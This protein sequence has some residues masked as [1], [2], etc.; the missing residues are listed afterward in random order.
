LITTIPH[1]LNKNPQFAR[2]ITINYTIPRYLIFE[3]RTQNILGDNKR[4]TGSLDF[5]KHFGGFDYIF[6]GKRLESIVT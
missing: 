6:D 4:A 1:S 3:L 2:G 5:M